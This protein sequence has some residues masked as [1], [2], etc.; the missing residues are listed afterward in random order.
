M[1]GKG[2]TRRPSTVDRETFARHWDT[3]FQRK[4]IRKPK[5]PSR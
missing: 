5:K 4:P 3:I 1:S 2:D